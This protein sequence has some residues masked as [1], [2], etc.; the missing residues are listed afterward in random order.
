MRW[1]LLTG[2]RLAAAA[3]FLAGIFAAFL[4]AAAAGLVAP[5]D[6]GR[7]IRVLNAVLAGLLTLIPITVGVNQIILSQELDSVR[8]LYERRDDLVEFRKPVE[9]GTGAP[10]SSPQ[11]SAFFE[12]LLSSLGEAIRTVADDV[13]ADGDPDQRSASGTL[14]DGDLATDVENYASTATGRIDRTTEAMANLDYD[15]ARTLF[16]LLQFEDAELFFA[17]RRLQNEHGAALPEGTAASLVEVREL[18]KEIDA[19]R[20]YLKTLVVERQLA[21]LSRLLIHTG[22]PAVTVAGLGILSFRDF[23][24]V[25]VPAPVVLLVA[26]LTLV[27]TLSPLAVLSSYVLRV[28]TIAHQTASFGPFIPRTERE[29]IEGL[30][31]E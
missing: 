28:A 23:P 30:E 2:D 18:F 20:Q 10:M 16:A 13:G 26:G 6:P 8:S 15:M 22:V 7:L 9:R 29:R 17:T 14:D 27:A 4:A 12:R 11:A 1:F 19:A 25:A 31:V 3:L 5:D 24:D 21:H